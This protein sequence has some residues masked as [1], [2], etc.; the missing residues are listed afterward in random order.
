MV[1]VVLECED[2]NVYQEIYEISK[3]TDD[4]EVINEKNFTGDITIVEMF[5]EALPTILAIIIPVLIE[6]IKKKKVS[7]LKIDGDIIELKNVSEELLKE[8]LEKKMNKE[9]VKNLDVKDE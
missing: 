8:V 2:L 5:F 4:F 9:D 3:N 1:Q 7:S 6:K